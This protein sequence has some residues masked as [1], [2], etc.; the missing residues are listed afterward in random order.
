MAYRHFVLGEKGFGN[1]LKSGK[2]R[3]KNG[4]NF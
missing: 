3:M 4:G 2:L 1:A